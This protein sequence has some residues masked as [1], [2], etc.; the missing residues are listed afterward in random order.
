MSCFDDAN[1]N[2]V[3]SYPCECGGDIVWTDSRRWECNQCD[4]IAGAI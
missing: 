1:Y 3:E 4:F 2:D